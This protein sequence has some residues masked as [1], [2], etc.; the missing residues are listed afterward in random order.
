[1]VYK[2]EQSNKIMAYIPLDELSVYLKSME[3]GESIWETALAWD[4]FVRDTIGKQL[5]RS[6]DS[7]AANISEGHG[8]FH[9]K[10]NK[11]FCYYS[12]GSLLETKT[13]IEKAFNRKLLSKDQFQKFNNDLDDIHL[14]L[15]K[16]IN[17]IGRVK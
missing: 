3:L 15:N 8:R 10:E 14:L 6:T 17:S 7:I 13:W 11:H 16:Y 9:Y 5:V 2:K 4:S 1:M 12:R